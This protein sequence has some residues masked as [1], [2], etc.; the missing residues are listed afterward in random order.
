MTDVWAQRTAADYAEAILNEMPDGP[1]WPRDA[2]SSLRAWAEGCAEIWGDNAARA[3]VLL[4][5]ESDPRSAS[6]LL[7]DWE[8]AFG[9]PDPCV[10]EPQT[11]TDRRRALVNKMTTQGGQ[12]RAFFIGVAAAL[13]YTITITEYSPFMAG[14][15]RA[16]DTRKLAPDDPTDVGYRW[17]V[18]PP[19]MR[20]WWRVH[21]I[22]AKL[23]WFRAGSGQAGVDP[24][25]RIGIA[26]DL[27]C[28]FRRWK[29]AHTALTFDYSGA[30]A[31]GAV[32][33]TWFRAG[34]GHAGIDPMLTITTTAGYLADT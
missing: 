34:S 1:A 30:S 2:D 29:P 24:M 13:G 25:V 16:G 14:I 31:S 3:A 32:A 5:D 17:Y 6:E 11:I 4:I 15:S 22:G 26:T 8:R 20:F 21:V 18:G 27:E 23:R 7:P 10:A 19:E 12:S 9:L 28:L 33:Y